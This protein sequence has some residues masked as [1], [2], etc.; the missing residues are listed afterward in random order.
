M[1][2]WRWS[3]QIRLPLPLASE[4]ILPIPTRPSW[5]AAPPAIRPQPQPA[6]PAPLAW[7][8]A[9]MPASARERESAHDTDASSNN[10]EIYAR[11]FYCPTKKAS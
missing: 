7:A 1:K 4:G 5:L 6:R 3:I 2:L 8:R 11:D 10:S 9:P